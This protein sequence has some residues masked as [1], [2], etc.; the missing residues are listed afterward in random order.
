MARRGPLFINLLMALTAFRSGGIEALVK[1]LAAVAIGGLRA[2]TIGLGVRRP[3]YLGLPFIVGA[4][5]VRLRLCDLRRRG[6]AGTGD[7][8]LARQRR[9]YQHGTRERAAKHRVTGQSVHRLTPSPM[10]PGRHPY[11]HRSR[12][13][14][15]PPPLDCRVEDYQYVEIDRRKAAP[16]EQKAR[17]MP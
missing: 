1:G 9:V 2:V 12:E 4:F 13:N 6:T 14:G 16:R 10:Q 5:H 11:L 3:G 17:E 15:A 8:I 7:S